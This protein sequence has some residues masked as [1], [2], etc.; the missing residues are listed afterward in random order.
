[1]W[2]Q[3]ARR[4]VETGRSQESKSGFYRFSTELEQEHF[5]IGLEHEANVIS[6]VVLNII[7]KYYSLIYLIKAIQGDWK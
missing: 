2:K 4:A 1:M 7:A 6:A 5:T 3:S